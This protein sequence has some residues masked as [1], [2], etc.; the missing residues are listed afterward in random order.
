MLYE[1][2]LESSYFGQQ[3]IN[4]WNYVSSGSVVGA[5]G[6]FALMSAMGFIDV[7]GDFPTVTVASRLQELQPSQV[8]YVSCL[9]K[10]LYDDPTDFLDRGY[11]AGVTGHGGATNPSS[12]ILAFGFRTNRTRT[13]ISRGTKRFVGVDETT[14]GDGGIFSAGTLGAMDNIASAMSE[15]L[16][17]TD[18]GS[19]LT[20]KPCIIGKKQVI[21]GGVVV[22]YELYPTLA[23][24]LDHIAQGIVW[25][26]YNSVRSQVSRQYGHGR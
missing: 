9:V 4:R 7:A 26:S 12:P 21:E 11:A 23:E 22:G 25:Q 20:L 24:Q 8:I 5:T 18:G 16:S 17:Y 13:D 14:V 3:I 2:T 1:V 19:S 15:D 6:S 10:A